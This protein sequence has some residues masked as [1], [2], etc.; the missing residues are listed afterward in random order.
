MDEH[1]PIVLS[2]LPDD[3]QQLQSWAERVAEVINA[4]IREREDAADQY[5][6]RLSINQRHWL[7][8]YSDLCQAAWLQALENNSDSVLERLHKVGYVAAD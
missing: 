5:C 4:T 3:E 8:T 1:P 2:Y 6:W 7:L